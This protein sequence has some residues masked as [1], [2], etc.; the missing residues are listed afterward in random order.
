MPAI[1][2]FLQRNLHEGKTFEDF[3]KAWFPP[4]EL[5]HPEKIGD[6]TY[7]HF[8]PVQTRVI[9]DINM[10]NPN[11]V[12]SIGL[13][14]GTEEELKDLYERVKSKKGNQIRSDSIAK[15]A[16]KVDLKICFVK[17]DDNL[18]K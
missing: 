7:H 16:D 6:M 8:F 3:H 11:E 4:K 1:I 13:T 18:G 14:W 2:S 9:N 10:E 15:V 5:T 17:S 12:I